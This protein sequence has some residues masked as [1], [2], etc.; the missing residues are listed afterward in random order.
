MK[1]VVLFTITFYKNI[2]SPLI[3][4]I[5]GKGNTCRYEPTCSIYAYQAIEKYGVIKGGAMSVRRISRCH[6]WGG[7]GFDPVR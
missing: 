5:F 7:K 3:D 1:S 6:P 4:T 2:I